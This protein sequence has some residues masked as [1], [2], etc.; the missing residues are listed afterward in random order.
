[1][2]SDA[3]SLV[4]PIDQ[5]EEGR[6]EHILKAGVA[7]LVPQALGWM[8]RHPTQTIA[9]LRMAWRL[10]GKGS[11][12]AP[13]TGGRLHHMIYLLEAAQIARRCHALGIQHVHAHFGTNSTTV[14]MLA[15]VLG[16]VPFS[17]TTHGP[18][19]FDAPLALGLPE[20]LARAKFAVGVSSFGRSQLYR[21]SKIADWPRIKVVHCGVEPERF[22]A[23]APMPTGGPHLVAIGRLSEQKGFP[24]LI[25]T[26]ALAAPRLPGLKL[27][28]VGDGELRSMI[29]DE[30][31]RHDLGN[32]I[33]LAGWLDEAGV[34]AA[35][36]ASQALVLPSLAEGLPMVVMEAMASGRPVIGTIINGVPELLTPDCGW[37]VPAGDPAALADAIC[38]MAK[39]PV[40][41]L[42][43]MGDRARIRAFDR[44]TTHTEATKLGTHLTKAING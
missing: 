25:E 14:A 13:G 27:T 11:G 38:E 43:E 19:E 40:E 6:T 35:L 10:G 20:K 26:M 9:G 22:D 8:I 44:H 2:R 17:F 7:R 24:V 42:T 28:I 4:D 16:G 30:I 41:K 23:P 32:C 12:G 3:A 37:L 29:E 31:K 5:A 33:T 15:E 1:M 36:S 21:W 39:T 18:E 34:R